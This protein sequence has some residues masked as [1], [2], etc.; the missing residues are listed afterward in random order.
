MNAGDKVTIQFGGKDV[1]C[2]CVQPGVVQKTKSIFYIQD[3]V[4][5]EWLYCFPAR[6]D[7]LN[8]KFNG[9]LSGFKGRATK[10][11]ERVQT[12][13]QKAQEKAE[14][15]AAKAEKAAKDAAK[16]VETQPVEA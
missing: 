11:I 13:E 5:G 10:A 6:L 8:A 12:K 15:K 16:V 4:S 7:R 1:E 2:T 3:S 14:K 9:D